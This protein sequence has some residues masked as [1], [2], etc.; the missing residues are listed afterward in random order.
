MPHHRALAVPEQPRERPHSELREHYDEIYDTLLD[1]RLPRD[2]GPILDVGCGDGATLQAIIEGTPLRA[3]ALDRAEPDRWHGPAEATRIRA[4]AQQ[5][6]FSERAFAGVLLVDTFE[7]LRHP[8]AALRELG[9]IVDGP[10]VVVQSDWPALWFDSEDPDLAREIVRLWADVP[11]EPLRERLRRA[12]ETAGLQIDAL[13]SVTIR[14]ESLA[15]GSLAADQLRAIRRWLVVERPQLRAR[16][17]DHWRKELDRRAAAGH[18]EM[19]LR[20]RIALF[21]PDP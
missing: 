17:F 12:A 3:A 13:C 9:R 6:P 10:I 21:R 11:E 2:A 18:F 15:P 16:R 8:V 20:R 7:W 19:L 1:G 5:L 4:D 14:A